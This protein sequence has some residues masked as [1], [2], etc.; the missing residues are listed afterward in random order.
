MFILLVGVACT[1]DFAEENTN[2]GSYGAAEVDQL[3]VNMIKDSYLSNE[4]FYYYSSTV[5]Y[6]LQYTVPQGGALR[7]GVISSGNTH[8]NRLYN[9]YPYGEEIRSKL[10]EEDN[11]KR[12]ISY[13]PQV[14][15]A[16]R[17]VK[18]FGD[19]PYSEAGKARLGGSLFPT[20]DKTSDIF[21]TLDSELSQ[22]VKW[23]EEAGSLE[24]KGFSGT[25]DF[26]YD[27]DAL[28]WGKLANVLRLEI[29]LTIAQRDKAMAQRICN[30][31]ASSLIGLFDSAADEYRLEPGKP[32][33]NTANSLPYAG[34]GDQIEGYASAEMVNMMKRCGDPR[35]S[36]FVLPSSLSEEGVAYLRNEYAS[37][38]AEYKEKI[39]NLFSV[40]DTTEKDL[41]VLTKGNVP[42]WRFI[43]GSPFV[44]GEQDALKPLYDTYHYVD[45]D[46]EMPSG[47]G[48]YVMSVMNKKIQNPDYNSTT[49][50]KNDFFEEQNATEE[51]G[52]YVLPVMPYSYMCF[53]LAQFDYLGLWSSPMGKNYQ[54][55]Y[56][57]GVRS[58]I[59]MYD[60]IAVNHKTNPY[61]WKRTTTELSEAIDN[62]LAHPDVQ[63]SGTRDWEKICIQQ[64][65]NCYHLEELGVDHVMRTGIPSAISS[66][67]RWGERPEYVTR[68][69]ALGRPQAEKDEQNWNEAMKRQGFSPG[70]SDVM[71]LHNERIWFDLAP[72]Y[73][74]GD[75]NK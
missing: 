31:V 63:L 21:L 28:K 2:P 72:D 36:I 13:I 34:G 44:G 24:G 58:S 42:S 18:E 8:Y 57:A 19:I 69:S 5:R 38:D 25:Y 46:K 32:M 27:G 10:G 54:D 75:I 35:L 14:M 43:G 30:E 68:R 23:L 67:Y 20:Y 37:G 56:V 22:A 73:G 50:L 64:Y 7:S 6:A 70:V 9:I 12:A 11:V 55:W 4:Y 45:W 39:E 26:M 15:L 62:Y 53:M 29:A 47:S 1:D 49:A 3:F 48:R 17:V 65:L 59:E 41:H 71:T 61:N 51:A 66:I 33:S 60:Y 40:I 52:Q 16:L 74:K